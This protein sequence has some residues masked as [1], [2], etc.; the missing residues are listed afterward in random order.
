MVMG[1]T[2]PI[3]LDNHATTK[4]DPRVIDAMLPYLSEVYGNASS[5]DHI[6][7]YTARDA[8]E[9]AREQ[10]ANFIG[11]RAANE[12]VFTSGATESDNL[13]LF[14]TAEAY[15]EKGNHIITCVTEHRAI[16]DSAEKLARSGKT[17]TFLPVDHYGRVDPQDV[18][19]AI[20]PHTILISIMMA[21]NEIGTIANIG[22]IGHIAHEHGVV[23]H[24]DAAQAVG[25][26]PVDVQK[27]N[28]DVLSLSAHKFYA[29]KGTGALYVRRSLPRIKLA[30]IIYGGGHERGMRS[31]TLNVPGIV[32]LAKA[33]EIAVKEMKKE[34]KRFQTWTTWMLDQ[35]RKELD[36]VELNGDPIE[37]LPH[38]LNISIEGVESKSL[39]IG[40]KDIAVSA[41]SACSSEK[42]KAEPSYVIKALGFG[43][44]RAHSAIRIGLGR[45]NT[46]EEIEYAVHRIIE[47]VKHIR[48]N[49][50][51]ITH[52]AQVSSTL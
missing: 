52:T 18:R 38:N 24:T 12:I 20:T 36:G 33:C 16:L 47:E 49:V 11:A 45:E 23:F 44:T 35:L 17:V 40:L 4:P 21:N 7:G 9:K 37:R 14:G 51:S 42:A 3:Y 34:A 6:F 43:E 48:E 46:Q 30:P 13:A 19:R 50:H 31:G 32:A 39:I 28:I 27:L 8:V 26:I 15:A 1:V 41:G 25:H 2:L 5:T 29:P 10:I 22:E